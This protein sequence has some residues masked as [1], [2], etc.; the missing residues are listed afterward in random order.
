MLQLIIQPCTLSVV[1][2][3]DVAVNY[4]EKADA[5][6]PFMAVVLKAHTCTC[7]DMHAPCNRIGAPRMLLAVVVRS[8][9]SSC[10]SWTNELTS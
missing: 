3:T 7:H 4:L 2:I 5:A 8:P 1:T 6:V 9:K 10:G